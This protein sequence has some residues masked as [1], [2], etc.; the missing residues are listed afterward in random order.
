MR[1]QSL[2]SDHLHNAIPFTAL[3]REIL[4]TEIF[5]R[6]HN[7]LQ[8]STAYLTYPSL[9]TS[10]F[11][12]SLG[13][14]HLAGEM[15]THGL[16]NA[17]HDD[18][19]A[20]ADELRVARRALA[21]EPLFKSL[22]RTARHAVDLEG[23]TNVTVP[24]EVRFSAAADGRDG[25][26]P[27]SSLDFLLFYQA[28]RVAALL[29]DIGHPPFSHITEFALADLVTEI[30]Q[31]VEA[32]KALTEREADFKKVLTVNGAWPTRGGPTAKL[33]ELLGLKFFTSIA[34]TVKER[35]KDTADE[36]TIAFQVLALAAGRKILDGQ[37]GIWITLHQIIA[38][39]LDADRLDYVP[40]DSSMAALEGSF[41]PYERI[42]NFYTLT[43]RQPEI[44]GPPATFSFI[45]GIQSLS[46][47][48]EFYQ[49]RLTLYSFVVN[50]HRVVKTDGLLKE[51]LQSLAR[52]WITDTSPLPV[53]SATDN[54][55]ALDI[56]YLWR[57]LDEKFNQTRLAENNHL[58]QWDDAWLLTTLRQAYYKLAVQDDKRELGPERQLTLVRLRELLAN[59]KLY[60]SLYKRIDE[61][62]DVDLGSLEHFRQPQAAD[63]L[64][65]FV[66]KRR[67]GREALSGPSDGRLALDEDILERFIATATT[68]PAGDQ[69]LGSAT[70]AVREAHGLFLAAL[71][72]VLKRTDDPNLILRDVA[73]HVGQTRPEVIRDLLLVPK[74]ISAG[75]GANFAFATPAG[76]TS[77]ADVSGL[78]L[79]LERRTSRVPMFYAYVLPAAAP[80]S[81]SLL[82]YYRTE[83]GKIL[84]EQLVKNLARICGGSPDV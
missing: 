9:R 69:N 56:A 22:V 18:R 21:E 20:F 5:S 16:A 3:E 45:P 82:S 25:S 8:M 66:Q 11:A 49:R 62:L 23:L 52:E 26:D 54:T 43:R 50:H 61:F 19:R 1:K 64:R 12:H 4:A 72:R 83:L 33:H 84:G 57:T 38:N 6:L 24:D 42:L 48:E 60:V 31:K 30:S 7:V 46:S 10:R 15:F 34:E 73:F 81:P 44:A 2:V 32:N 63:V 39:E 17:S 70:K 74:H 40:R 67:E 58:V 35:L 14:M 68:L 76:T 41:F 77:V 29:H 79:E 78:R 71:F 47:I 53:N 55:L 75:L 37:D 51:V 27:A 28:L 65:R 13:C 36:A 80:P 59:R